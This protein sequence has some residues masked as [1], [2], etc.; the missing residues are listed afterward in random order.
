MKS[1]PDVRKKVGDLSFSESV[2]KIA[3][4]A[5]SVSWPRTNEADGSASNDVLIETNF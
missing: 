5:A 3:R 1:R 2:G 4:G